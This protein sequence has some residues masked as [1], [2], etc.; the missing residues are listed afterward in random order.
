MVQAAVAAPAA[1]EAASEAE[2]QASKVVQRAITFL[3]QDVF[4][5][6]HQ[7]TVTKTSSDGKKQ[8]EENT[9]YSAG[10][11]VWELGIALLALTVWEGIQIFQKDVSLLESAGSWIEGALKSI[12]SDAESGLTWLGE[13]EAKLFGIDISQKKKLPAMPAMPALAVLDAQLGVLFAQVLGPINLAGGAL[14]NSVI[15]QVIKKGAKL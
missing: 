5:W 11:K 12:A 15:A 1:A 6:T 9:V 10:V 13:E 8:I 14:V 4:S 3:D 7:R 2:D